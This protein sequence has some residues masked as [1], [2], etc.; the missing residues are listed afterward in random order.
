MSAHS[1]SPHHCSSH[2]CNHSLHKELNINNQLNEECKIYRLTQEKIKKDELRAA[3]KALKIKLKNKQKKRTGNTDIDIS[4]NEIQTDTAK[5]AVIM[6][7]L[8][9]KRLMD[10]MGLGHTLPS[11][12]DIIKKYLEK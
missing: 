7:H 5:R 2:T 12:A 6:E 10:A 8:A 11:L 4:G 1:H 3:R 9:K